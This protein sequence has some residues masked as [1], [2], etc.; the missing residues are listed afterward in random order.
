MRRLARRNGINLSCNIHHQDFLL[1][2]PKEKFDVIISN[3]P[4]FKISKADPRAQ[5]HS[6]LVH[7]QPNIY[8]LFM[9]VCAELLT[10]HGRYC[11]LTPR[12]WTS[13]KYFINPRKNIIKNIN[14]DAFHLF[15]N[16]DSAFLEDGIQQEMMITWGTS[17]KNDQREIAIS[18]SAGANDLTPLKS[19]QVSSV[20]IFLKNSESGICLPFT[21]ATSG[22]I[23]FPNT[24]ISIGMKASTGKVVPFRATA[25]LKSHAGRRR[26]P[27]YWM[28]H[29]KPG[30][31]SWPIKHPNEYI[32]HNLK[33]SK[34]LIP[35]K[36]YVFVRRFSPRDSDSWI[37]AAPYLSTNL[38]PSIGVENHINFIYSTSS[39][40]TKNEAAGLAIYLSSKIVAD[41]FSARIGHTQINA[42]DLNTLPVPMRPQLAD[43]GKLNY[44]ELVE[45]DILR[46]IR[47][48]LT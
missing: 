39:D 5:L 46:H 12:S 33:S 47:T 4:F 35:D 19:T 30:L 27:L 24:L 11:F 34:I 40:L 17:Q 20:E 45:E 36:N 22:S 31:I 8:A 10:P 48:L 28:Q 15:Q 3:P 2:P 29:I 43:L 13:G 16:R 37:T 32:L 9:A 41:Y 25:W 18:T 21:G 14:V 38:F 26:V 23:D 42:S 6:R 1:R 7:G 44:S